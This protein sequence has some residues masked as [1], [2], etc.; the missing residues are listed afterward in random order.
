MIKRQ[1]NLKE[2]LS[3]ANAK[4]LAKSE[5]VKKYGIFQIG[6]VIAAISGLILYITMARFITAS[7]IGVYSLYFYTL[8][9][10]FS[11]FSFSLHNVLT[12]LTPFYLTENRRLS[13]RLITGN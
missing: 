3:M 2:M 7:D 11:V 10:L 4:S 9:L 6:N 13:P 1:D 8:S 5:I 12:I